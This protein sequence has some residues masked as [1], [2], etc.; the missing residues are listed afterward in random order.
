M[1]YRFYPEA[2]SNA[3]IAT[4]RD[5]PE[6]KKV[7]WFDRFPVTRFHEEAGESIVEMSDMRFPQFAKTIHAIHLPISHLTQPAKFSLKALQ[8]EAQS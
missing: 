4:A 7:L 5:L 2:P 8:N 3:F 1:E 6:V